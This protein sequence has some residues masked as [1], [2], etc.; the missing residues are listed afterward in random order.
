MRLRS[1]FWLAICALIFV[2]TLGSPIQAQNDDTPPAVAKP[3]IASAQ[4]LAFGRFIALIR[5]HL[6][7]GDELAGQRDWEGASRHFGFPREEI[8]GIIRDDLRS[9]KAP[10]FDDALRALVR[11]AKARDAKQVQKARARVEDALAAGDAG[12]KAKVPNWPRFVA[13]ASIAVLKTAPDE[14]DDAIVKG[15]IVHPIG[16]QTARGF[17][18]QADKMFDGVAAELAGDN[19]A[20]LRICPTETGFSRCECT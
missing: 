20:A 7:T 12:L 6:L 16:Y 4:D 10:P 9:Y 17:I 11:A 14:Y 5:G 3:A 2:A 1:A 8:Y 13:T 18:L 15:R 19:T